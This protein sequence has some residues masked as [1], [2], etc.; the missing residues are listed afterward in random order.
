TLGSPTYRKQT[1]PNC[2]GL[3][4]QRIIN[5]CIQSAYFV[6]V[7][8]FLVHLK[9]GPPERVSRDLLNCVADCLGRCGKSYIRYGSHRPRLV[10][11]GEQLRGGAIVETGHV[12][13][14]SA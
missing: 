11:G 2:N 14:Q 6:G 10:S 3:S 4:R 8:P 7:E 5:A 13:S 1:V 12:K 9:K